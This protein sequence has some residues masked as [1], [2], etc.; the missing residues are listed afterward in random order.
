MKHIL[1]RLILCITILINSHSSFYPL[2]P[3]SQLQ[4]LNV[5]LPSLGRLAKLLIPVLSDIRPDYELSR[6]GPEIFSNLEEIIKTT[7]IRVHSY[8]YK[9]VSNQHYE[10]IFYIQDMQG[11]WLNPIVI[12]NYEVEALAVQAQAGLL[13]TQWGPANYKGPLTVPSGRVA[14]YFT[15]ELNSAPVDVPIGVPF[16]LLYRQYIIYSLDAVMQKLGLAVR[17]TF[18]S[19]RDIMVPEQ[20]P[21]T[22][23]YTGVS[24]GL[25]HK[26]DYR[27]DALTDD[28]Y[29]QYFEDLYQRIDQFFD[30]MR[31]IIPVLYPS[32][33]LP[34]LEQLAFFVRASSEE[35]K[36][37]VYRKWNDGNALGFLEGPSESMFRNMVSKRLAE[38]FLAIGINVRQFN[39]EKNNELQVFGR[40]LD[41]DLKGLKDKYRQAGQALHDENLAKEAVGILQKHGF[42]A[43]ILEIDS[44]NLWHDQFDFLPKTAGLKRSVVL[45]R[46]AG[47]FLLLDLTA[48]LFAP[49]DKAS[50]Y[51][52]QHPIPSLDG[53]G[54]V[55]PVNV[56]FNHLDQYQDLGVVIVPIRIFWHEKM[57][58]NL[59]LKIEPSKDPQQ[60]RDDKIIYQL[61]SVALTILQKLDRED[62]VNLDEFVSGLKSLVDISDM[63]ELRKRQVELSKKYNF[64]NENYDPDID[65]EDDQW[66]TDIYQG[67]NRQTFSLYINDIIAKNQGVRGLYRDQIVKVARLFYPYLGAWQLLNVDSSQLY[68]A[69]DM[70]LNMRL[71]D[72]LGLQVTVFFNEL[73]LHYLRISMGTFNVV[74]FSR[75]P[76]LETA[77]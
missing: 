22:K 8:Q 63:K 5:V 18:V 76:A 19:A 1:L 68:S 29:S 17:D 75:L 25:G 10:I 67:P 35:L 50:F 32:G 44:V 69:R 34:D 74:D 70:N 6:K 77:A 38:I 64:K 58:E 37:S 40:V 51:A 21:D 2:A 7:G 23:K 28:K 15:Y 53:K 11:R 59:M 46:V 61:R 60:T 12:A 49:K 36:E 13:S 57:Q 30:W 20:D 56:N 54:V 43:G 41:T 72:P 55:N 66:N 52:F 27:T 62:D 45:V 31:K 42:I 4:D 9:K 47:E 65:D 39:A 73:L 3:K 16:E 26:Y 48:D 33:G 14:N 71:L 24:L